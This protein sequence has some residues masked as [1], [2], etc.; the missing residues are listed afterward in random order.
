[1]D[2]NTK[3]PIFSSS[4]AKTIGECWW[5]RGGMGSAALP[6]LSKEQ[7]DGRG[8]EEEE[9]RGGRL[10]VRGMEA[11]IKLGAGDVVERGV[12]L[13]NHNIVIVSKRLAHLQQP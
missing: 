10:H 8:K 11:Y 1:L 5:G 9:L 7:E 3:G 2:Q 13:G 4:P 6:G 12:H